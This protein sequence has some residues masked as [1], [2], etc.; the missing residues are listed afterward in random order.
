M[1][2]SNATRI[3]LTHLIYI[4]QRDIPFPY[5]VINYVFQVVYGYVTFPFLL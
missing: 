5:G 2:D 1:G 4:S 3:N